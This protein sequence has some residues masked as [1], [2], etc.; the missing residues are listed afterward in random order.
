MIIDVN[1][2]WLPR[3]L[4]ADQSI[5]NAFIRCI[6]R[7][8][9]E[10]V[11]VLKVPGSYK[12][13]IIISKPKGCPN[14]NMSLRRVDNED[15][16]AV[17]DQVGVDKT[18]LRVAIWEEW[19]TLELCKKVND[20]MAETIR[21][22]P[23]RLLGLA[24]VPPWAD[25]DCLYEL[26]RCIKELGF[27][28]IEMPAHYGNLYLDEEEFRPHFKK[29]NQLG[30][31]I[32]IHH[33]P[34]PVEYESFTKYTNLRRT[35]GRCVAQ[36]TNL[37]RILSSELLDECPNL[38]L[39]PT[40]LGGGFFAYADIFALSRRDSTV[41]EDYEYIDRIAD[42]VSSYLEKN[43]YFDISHAPPWG[44][45]QLECAVKVLGADHILWGSSY[46]L[47]REFLIKGVDFIRDLD[48]TEKDKSLI[49]GENA[50]RVFNIK[51]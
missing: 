12:E 11:E 44:K 42:K 29:I 25:N 39:I 22:H 7:A 19:L 37:M 16:L 23:D 3:Q 14:L 43:I 1:A 34:L 18:I 33:V 30:V 5:Q 26:E 40:L 51:S 17:M 10:H 24:T 48:I 8:Y 49:L 13:Q 2:H 4:F 45:A 50:K 35:Y 31:P 38:K 28:G 36:M 47:R 46:P 9:G 6:P 32:A 41:Q 27:V 20:W 15:R 21:E